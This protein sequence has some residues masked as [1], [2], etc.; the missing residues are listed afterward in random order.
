MRVFLVAIVVISLSLVF[1]NCDEDNVTGNGFNL[2]RV[3]VDLQDGF[4]GNF[5]RVKFNDTVHFSAD[6]KEMAPLAGP[7]ARFTTYLP[8]GLNQCEIFW[9]ENY[10]SAHQP[11]NIDSKEVNLDNAEIYYMGISVSNDSTFVI[12]LKE[13]PFGYF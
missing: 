10:G 6:L 2:V 5:V 9:Q 4:D 11:Y 7:L 12:D 3:N 8:R 1:I 13:K